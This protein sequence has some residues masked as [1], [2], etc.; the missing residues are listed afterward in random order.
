[1]LTYPVST[2]STPLR[3]RHQFDRGRLARVSDADVP[4]TYWQLNAVNVLGQVAD[5]T[6]GN[7]VRVASAY[8]SVTGRLVARTAG[9]GGGTSHQ[10]LAFAWDAVGNLL[11]REERNRGVYEQ[12]VYDNR[13]RL[14]YVQRA[15]SVTLDLSYDETGNIT[16]KSDVG[17]Y[18]YDTVRKHAVVAAGANTYSL[19]RER[20]RRQCERHVDQAGSVTTCRASSRI[21]PATIRRSTT[22]RI[23]RGIARS[24]MPAAR[25]PRR[26]TRRADSTSA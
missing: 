5:E 10:N 7:G 11:Q 13:D 24:P 6:L 9:I 22:G 18:R 26:C 8:D 25:S 3:V 14:D 17:N 12:F 1:M 19:R 16:Y 2:G 20:R 23:A 15:G 21:P 4:S